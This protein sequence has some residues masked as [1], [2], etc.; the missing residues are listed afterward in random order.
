MENSAEKVLRKEVQ[1]LVDK[2]NDI[3]ENGKRKQRALVKV[4]ENNIE[5]M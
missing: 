4:T 1:Q 5:E 3:S 2:Y